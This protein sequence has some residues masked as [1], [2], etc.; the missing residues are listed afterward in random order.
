[1]SN[2]QQTNKK[3]QIN[4]VQMFIRFMNLI[5]T[6]KANI[7][8][9]LII[10]IA[11]FNIRDAYAFDFEVKVTIDKLSAQV[12]FDNTSETDFY[13]RVTIDGTTTNNYGTPGQLVLE[14][15]DTIEPGLL[16]T[17]ASDWS[18][19]KLVDPTKGTIPIMIEIFDDDDGFNFGDDQADIFNGPGSN[20]NLTLD[21]TT[22]TFTGG[23]SGSCGVSLSSSGNGDADGNAT[24]EFTVEI[25]GFNES[26]GVHIFCIHEPI[27]P[28]PGQQV[29]ITAIAIADN[30][31]PRVVDEIA[32]T[33]GTTSSVLEET[34]TAVS[35]FTAGPFNGPDFNYSCTALNDENND[36]NPNGPDPGEIAFSGY[37]TV[38]VGLPQNSRAVPL[39]KTGFESTRQDIVLIPDNSSFTGAMDG[40]FL[41]DVQNM[42]ELYYQSG[43]VLLDNQGLV[44]FWIA[45]DT[46]LAGGFENSVCDNNT[47]NNWN[48]DYTFS[49]SGVILHRND[50]RDC[51]GNGIASVQTIQFVNGMPVPFQPVVG[52][53]PFV[54]ELG[55][56]LF[57]LADEYCYTRPGAN[58]NSSCDGG[59]WQAL[60]NPNLYMTF[61]SCETD[62]A[63]DPN[64]GTKTCQ[65]FASEANSTSGQT[66]FTFDPPAKDMMVDNQ[67]PQFLDNRRINGV[68]INC[69]GC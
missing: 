57:G 33:Q 62:R 47:P 64:G 20:L 9:A 60:V 44:N 6:V 66:F 65:S 3:S 41:Q 7:F 50:L 42:I 38:T 61:Q 39:I 34:N 10:S 14:G 16:N 69:T 1:M 63:T 19:S 27:W 4:T 30:L 36:G 58:P 5:S 28:Q 45:Q 59:Y 46:G 55:H 22:C 15:N 35:V 49:N 12:S 52:F 24:I 31:K 43:L 29:K 26:S 25:V 21:L 51:A 32:I 13:A 48:T 68:F 2:Q 56:A 67:L 23:V 40:D 37:R 54:H 53:T 17:G 8:L 11:P 18:F